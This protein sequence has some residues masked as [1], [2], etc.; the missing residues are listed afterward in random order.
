V[1]RTREEVGISL[2]GKNLTIAFNSRYLLDV[3]KEVKD[4]SLI[5]DFN[6]SISPCVIRPLQGESFYYLVLPVKTSAN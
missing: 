6:T 4:D 5:F 3:L 2:T 1:G